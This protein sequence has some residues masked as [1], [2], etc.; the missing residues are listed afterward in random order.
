[1][2]RTGKKPFEAVLTYFR[3]VPL[4]EA[5]LVF[6][7][8]KVEIAARR[9]AAVIPVPDPIAKPKGKKRGPKPG[10]KRGPKSGSSTGPQATIEGIDPAPASDPKV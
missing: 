8:V 2:P 7:L 1:M 4:A 3:S 5:D 9:E 6:H 10:S